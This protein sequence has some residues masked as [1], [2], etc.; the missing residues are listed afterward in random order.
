MILQ[1]DR[2]TA[3]W[4]LG[5]EPNST[6]TL[7]VSETSS[8]SLLGRGT[9]QANQTGGWMVSIRVSSKNSTTLVATDS[10]GASASLEDV[11]WGGDSKHKQIPVSISVHTSCILLVSQWE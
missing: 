7:S 8:H 6:V 11:A 4:G 3:I 2:L 9:A 1:S 10:S 5:A